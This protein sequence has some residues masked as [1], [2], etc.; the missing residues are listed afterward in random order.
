MC[1]YG[2]SYQFLEMLRLVNNSRTRGQLLRLYSTQYKVE[3]DQDLKEFSLGDGKEKAFLQYQTLPSNIIEL[4]HTVVPESFQG[5]GIGK[6][7]AEAALEYA[8]DKKLTVK[9]TCGFVQKYLEK[10]PK[11]EFKNVLTH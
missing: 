10:N 9:V 2:G 3:H 8:I 11:P 6:L 7:L 4:E 5:K 1:G